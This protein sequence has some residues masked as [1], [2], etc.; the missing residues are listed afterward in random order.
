ME[1]FGDDALHTCYF[2]T[3]VAPNCL[4]EQVKLSTTGNSL[5][6]AHFTCFAYKPEMVLFADLGLGASVARDAGLG[7]EGGFEPNVPLD[8]NQRETHCIFNAVRSIL[9]TEVVFDWGSTDADGQTIVAKDAS[10]GKVMFGTMTR[11]QP[12]DVTLEGIIWEFHRIYSRILV[13][14]IARVLE[15][16]KDRP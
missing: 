12:A 10:S 9:E 8:F 5:A 1:I 13:C 16:S 11:L 3:F 4:S 6:R 2:D 7:Y 15:I 14:S